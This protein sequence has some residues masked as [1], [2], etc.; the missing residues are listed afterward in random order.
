SRWR[1]TALIPRPPAGG[2]HAAVHAAKWRP[3]PPAGRY[4]R[5]GARGRV[6]ARGGLLVEQDRAADQP[7][8]RV[9]LRVVA[10]RALRDRVVLLGQQAGR[11]GTVDDLLEELLG[12]GSPPGEQVRL[13]HPRGAQ[14]EA[15]LVA[16]QAVV[17]PVA[18]DSGAAAEFPFDR[19]D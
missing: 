7:E 1:T 18:V 3:H 8:V 10:Q 13:D 6:V 4:R 19:G 14:V 5:H 16:G 15:A 11:A 2:E 9:R 12:L 17:A